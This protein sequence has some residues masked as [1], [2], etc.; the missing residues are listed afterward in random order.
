MRYP[1]ERRC[2][3]ALCLAAALTV[4]APSAVAQA[5]LSGTP[6]GVVGNAGAAV[7]PTPDPVVGEVE[8]RQI[9]LSE[10]GDEIRQ[11]PG[12]EANSFQAMYPVALRRLIERTAIVI[13]A[14][15]DGLA[16]DAAVKRHMQEA[17]DKALEDA[18]LQHATAA[19]VSESMLLARYNT[20]IRGKPGPEEVH[21]RAILVPTEAAAQ[22]IITKLAA[23]AD[24]ATLARQSSIDPTAGSGG[25]LGF[26]RRDRINPIL[27]AVLF[28]LPAGQVTAYPVQTPAG[29]FVLQAE[30]RRAAPTPS[31]AAARETLMGQCQR[32]RVFAVVR[33]ALAG[34]NV[35][36]YDMNGHTAPLAGMDDDGSGDPD[37]R[38]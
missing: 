7:P 35:H 32:D 2:M 19:R 24:F 26:V 17:A 9:R 29:W 20:D 37:G 33:A 23:G 13:R 3:Q 38:H 36:A 16:D 15:Q 1:G 10:L 22:G 11:L 34:M 28:S 6:P 14:H 25:D 30:A 21:G 31:F 4:A 5:V 27:A 12:G 8:G 18:Y